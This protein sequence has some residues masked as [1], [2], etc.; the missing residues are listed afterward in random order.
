MIQYYQ[1]FQDQIT[2]AINSMLGSYSSQISRAELEEDKQSPKGE[3][4]CRVQILDL[5]IAL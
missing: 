4:E 1:D 5:G 2:K 3:K